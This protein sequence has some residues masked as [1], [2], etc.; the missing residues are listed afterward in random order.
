MLLL[1]KKNIF[2]FYLLYNWALDI[3]PKFFRTQSRVQLFDNRGCNSST[4]VGATPRQPRGK[5]P[6][7]R[8]HPLPAAVLR[9]G[10]G[11]F[12][13]TVVTPLCRTATYFL[14]FLDSIV[15]SFLNLVIVVVSCPSS[16]FS[17]ISSQCLTVS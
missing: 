13:K 16:V 9:G 10:G 8:R 7:L 17:R 5:R 6:R 15:L 14:N 12:T 1:N 2:M 11:D 3:F 4:I